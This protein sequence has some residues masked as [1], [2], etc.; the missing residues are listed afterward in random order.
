VSVLLPSGLSRRAAAATVPASLVGLVVVMLAVHT[1]EGL[2]K[3]GIAG[4]GRAACGSV[5][6]RPHGGGRRVLI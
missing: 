2:G 6:E 4:P 3:V 1:L 5:P